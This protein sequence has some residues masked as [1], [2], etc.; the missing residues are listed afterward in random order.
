MILEDSRVCPACEYQVSPTDQS[1]PN[2]GTYLGV[3]QPDAKVLPAP[4]K[5]TDPEPVSKKHDTAHGHTVDC[6]FC[7]NRVPKNA[8]FCSG[9]GKKL[10]GEVTKFKPGLLSNRGLIFTSAIV[11]IFVGALIGILLLGNLLAT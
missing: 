4:L 9:C 2:C 7:A 3:W 1:C 11:V 8:H 6:P 10:R 5:I